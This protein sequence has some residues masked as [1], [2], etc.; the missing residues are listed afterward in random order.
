MPDPR[1]LAEQSARIRNLYGESEV[2]LLNRVA[3]RVARGIT[4]PGWTEA[5]LLEVGDLAR[6]LRVA[7]AG[8]QPA[9]A[10]EL[11]D[12]L[13]EAYVNGAES[14]GATIQ[15][16]IPRTHVAAVQALYSQVLGD[17]SRTNLVILRRS[18]DIYRSVVG[19]S[20]AFAVAGVETRQ[21]VTQRALDRWA[22]HGIRGFTDTRGRMWDLG[23]Y[24]EMAT[25]SAI[26]NAHLEGRLGTFRELGF[27]LYVVSGGQSSCP[28]CNEWAGMVLSEQ[29]H[30][31]AQGTLSQARSSG[32][33]HPNCGHSINVYS[34]G[35]SSEPMTR[36][37]KKQAA[38]EYSQRQQQRA[39][40][41]HVREWKRRQAV[42]ITPAASAK[43][44]AKIK[45]YQKALRQHTA[46]TGQRRLYYREQPLRGVVS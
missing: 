19:E 11:Q 28:L 37:D 41:R 4:T 25:R 22:M 9:L 6:E 20:A 29:P 12:I 15:G 36:T 23:S 1:T 5:K 39:L 17:F 44:S 18:L 7:T 30:P 26:T 8:L 43:A 34:R 2:I 31:E 16:A 38:V 46:R 13:T 21:Q 3:K 14:A 32:L 24:S 42:A 45:E 10:R 33:F 40:E 35:Y 27:T